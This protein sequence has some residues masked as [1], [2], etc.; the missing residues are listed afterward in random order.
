MEFGSYEETTIKVATM[1]FIFYVTLN[2]VIPHIV[3]PP[4]PKTFDYP[5]EKYLYYATYA[6][7]INSMIIPILGNYTSL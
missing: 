5:E 1:S 3:K 6:S 4:V 7:F 2:L